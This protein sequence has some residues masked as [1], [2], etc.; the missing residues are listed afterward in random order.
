M[1]IVVSFRRMWGKDLFYPENDEAKFIAKLIGRPTIPRRQ[2]KICFD[3]GWKIKV[4]SQISDISGYI[5]KMDESH[6]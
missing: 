3:Y 5:I 1:N 6:E 4:V 2:L